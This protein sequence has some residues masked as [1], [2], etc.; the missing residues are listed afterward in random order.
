MTRLGAIQANATDYDGEIVVE[1]FGYWNNAEPS[2]AVPAW[3]ENGS[4]GL[5]GPFATI[6]DAER[7]IRAYR[8]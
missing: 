4:A 6:A 3:D 2:W 7:A 8:A 5:G 1:Q